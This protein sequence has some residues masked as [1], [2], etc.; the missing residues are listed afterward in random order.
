MWVDVFGFLLCHMPTICSAFVTISRLLF[1]AYS[2][3]PSYLSKLHI[4][5]SVTCHSFVFLFL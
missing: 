4:I 2:E 1:P 3:V 5:Q